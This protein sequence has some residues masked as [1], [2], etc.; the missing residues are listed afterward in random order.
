MV[1]YINY[2]ININTYISVTIKIY[3]PETL[4]CNI[5]VGFVWPFTVMFSSIMQFELL[6]G[7]VKC[8]KV[9][10]INI[11]TAIFNDTNAWKRKMHLR[12]Y[13]INK[14][15]RIKCYMIILTILNVSMFK[16]YKVLNSLGIIFK[17]SNEYYYFSKLCKTKVE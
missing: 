2:F 16:F 13:L 8:I 9:K 1:L 12:N 11:F 7:I 5:Y 17:R 10:C 15:H 6:E 4:L 14:N 3:M